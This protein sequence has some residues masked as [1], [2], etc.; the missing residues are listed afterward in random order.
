MEC[1]KLVCKDFWGVTETN[2]VSPLAL[3]QNQ[4]ISSRQFEKVAIVTRAS[5]QAWDDINNLLHK[6]GWL[7][8]KKLQTY[9]AIEELLKLLQDNNAPSE[10]M[11]TFFNYVDGSKR[12]QVAK[13]LN[14]F[15]IVIDVS[16]K[17]FEYLYARLIFEKT[18]FF[19][20]RFSNLKEIVQLCWNIK[21]DFDLILKNIF[22]LKMFSVVFL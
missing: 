9:L 1:L 15:K 10:V 8:G 16:N 2:I 12:L 20:L 19:S 11:E 5:L 21:P 17:L 6:K 18:F 22:M 7:G 14:C 13:S 3:V 4:D